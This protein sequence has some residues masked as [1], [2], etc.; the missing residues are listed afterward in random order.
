MKL[1]NLLVGL[2]ALSAV[3]A[4]AA[5]YCAVSAKTAAESIAKLNGAKGVQENI[6]LNENAFQLNMKDGSSYLVQTEAIDGDCII[7][8]VS[9]INE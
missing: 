1:R 9:M 5:P 2:L 4:L 6:V 3:N 8:L 7:K